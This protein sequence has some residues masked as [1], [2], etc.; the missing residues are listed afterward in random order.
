MADEKVEGRGE[1][2]HRKEEQ[3]VH[4]PRRECGIGAKQV[5]DAH[6]DEELQDIQ[7]VGGIAAEGEEAAR[8]ARVVSVDTRDAGVSPA[9]VLVVGVVYVAYV[10]VEPCVEGGEH[11]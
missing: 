5:A 10:A 8:G 6:I 11:G 9:G 7:P 2:E 3:D 4:C 1:R